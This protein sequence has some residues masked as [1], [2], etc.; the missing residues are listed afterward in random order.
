MFFSYGGPEGRDIA[1]NYKVSQVDQ[2][3]SP[4][5]ENWKT[6]ETCHE[7]IPYRDVGSIYLVKEHLG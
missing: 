1:T 5:E 3:S 6:F 2:V 4:C 7:R